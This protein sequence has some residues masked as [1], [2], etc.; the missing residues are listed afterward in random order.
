MNKSKK[1]RKSKL[2]VAYI[3]RVGPGMPAGEWFRC[4]WLVVGTVHELHD[5]PQAVKVLGEELCCFAIARANS[6]CLASIVRTAA[7][8]LSTAIS[9]TAVCV[10]HIMAGCS[11]FTAIVWKMPAE[12]ENSK[13]CAKV[14]QLS[15][16]VRELGGLIFAYLGPD[17]AN[18]PPL[19]QYAPLLDLGGQR[20]VEP[21]R[22]VHHD[23]RLPEKRARWDYRHRRCTFDGRPG[24]LFQADSQHRRE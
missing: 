15:Y 19:P 24:R 8:R 7:P 14:Q 4:Y 10:A 2:T 17:Q 22:H 9:K 6:V 5:I 21:V 13:F 16:P 1:S 3:P 12:P 18:L 11:T 20:Q 23:W